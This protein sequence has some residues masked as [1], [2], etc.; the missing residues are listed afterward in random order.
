MKRIILSTAFLLAA[1]VAA[2]AQR[3]F[4]HFS[5]PMSFALGETE[6][7]VG[8]SSFRGFTID[9]RAFIRNNISIGGMWS[10]EVFD[11]VK[12]GLPPQPVEDDNGNV[13]GHISGT[14]YTYLNSIPIMMNGHYYLGENGALRP[15]F[16]LGLGTVYVDERQDV[17]FITTQTKTW[18]FGL[19]PEIGVFIPFGLTD[20]GANVSLRYRYATKGKEGT[21]TLSFLSLTVGLGF[22]N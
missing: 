3:S 6:E 15:Y 7:F 16:G 21:R 17:G 2:N 14:P 12:R 18:R 19:Q 1:I 5:Y 4:W 13:V 20:T 9:G 8:G 11:E 22:M 10:W